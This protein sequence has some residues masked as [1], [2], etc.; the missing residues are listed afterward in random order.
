MNRAFFFI[1][2]FFCCGI[3]Y[4]YAQLGAGLVDYSKLLST[5]DSTVQIKIGSIK[6]SGNYRTKSYIIFREIPFKEGNYFF[7]KALTQQLELA[8][9]QIMNTTLFIDVNVYVSNL[10]SGAATVNIDVKERWYLFPLPYFKLVDRNFNQWWSDQNGSLERVNYGLKFFHNNV[11]GR[12]DKLNI[13]LVNGYN[14]QVVFG[15]NQP[16]AD[17]SLKHGF[18]V[19]FIYSR[20]REMNYNTIDN[21]QAF[22]K[23]PEF[24]REFQKSSITYSYRPDSK[25]RFNARIGYTRDQVNDTILKLNPEYFPT[26]NNSLKFFD[27][28]ANLQYFAVDYIPFPKKGFMYDI[29]IHNRGFNSNM[30]MLSLSIETTNAFT[31]SKNWFVQLHNVGVVRMNDNQ[32]YY[33]RGLM[34]YGDFYLRGMESYVVDG[35]AGF[36][37]NTTLYRKLFTYVFHPPFIKTKTHDKIPFTFYL[38]VFGDVGYAYNKQQNIKSYSNSF[39]PTTGIGLDIVSIY[40]F[41]FRIEYS[42]NQYGDKGFALRTRGDF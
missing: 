4:C 28:S 9:D 40:D 29:N 35:T 22:I 10:V 6:L 16:F 23:L 1:F 27:V 42:F 7:P 30:N 11:S 8:K 17:K 36:I 38:K 5:A 19:N 39:L 20:Q 13:D 31:L 32:P 2:I 37:S 18:S 33:N 21:K 15:Y 12:N 25:Y 24:I 34:G 26:A 3:N 41:V 14:Q